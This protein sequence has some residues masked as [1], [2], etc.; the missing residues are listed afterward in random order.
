MCEENILIKFSFVHFLKTRRLCDSKLVFKSVE[1]DLV[2]MNIL[3]ANKTAVFPPLDRRG[4]PQPDLTTTEIIIILFMLLL[5]IYSITLTVRAW[6]KIMSDGSSEISEGYQ[7]WRILLEAI[8]SRS[9][10]LSGSMTDADLGR[11][12]YEKCTPPRPGHSFNKT[13]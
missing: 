13:Y 4:V 3:A 1:L 5:W 7:W 12:R 2:E 6:H 8:R 10:S 11:E 9:K